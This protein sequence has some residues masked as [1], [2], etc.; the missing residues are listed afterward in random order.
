MISRALWAL[1]AVAAC[2]GNARPAR[3]RVLDKIPAGVTAVIAADARALAHPRLRAIVDVVRGELP[4]GLDCVVDAVLA[5]DHVAAGLGAAGDITIALVTRA[6]VRCPALGR[7]EDDVWIATIGA[8][9]PASGSSVLTADEHGR[10]RPF[11]R[12][13][14]VALVAARGSVRVLATAQPEPLAAWAAFDAADIPAATALARAVETAIKSAAA[15]EAI[16]PIAAAVRVERTG[17]QVVARLGATDADLGVAMRAVLDRVH[18]VP[19]ARAFP[20][21][22]RAR[23]PVVRCEQRTT[24]H[25]RLEV[26]S[27]ASVVEE[28]VA[29]RKEA[30]IVGGRVAGVRLR[31]SLAAYGLASGDTLVAIDGRRLTSVDDAASLLGR[32]RERT[33]LVVARAERLGTIELVEH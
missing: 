24:E 14:P 6:H 1:A 31:D 15:S 21:P 3:D 5:G 18:A 4:A 10:A 11:L 26:Y 9:A 22:D 25:N 20:C 30:V 2:G 16:A 12:D 33:A 28:L 23:P 17:S 27:L 29:A 32:V 7:G 19:P 8:G 13:A